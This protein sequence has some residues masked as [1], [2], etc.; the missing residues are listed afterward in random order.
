MLSTPT[1]ILVER[2][3]ELSPADI[4]ARELEADYVSHIMIENT[5]LGVYDAAYGMDDFLEVGEPAPSD[6]A[7]Q[8]LRRHLY[9]HPEL[10]EI[11]RWASY[12]PPPRPLEG[13]DVR[14][15]RPQRPERPA[16]SRHGRAN[17]VGGSG[18]GEQEVP[19]G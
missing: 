3:R 14:L 6:L 10:R 18:T 5:P 8:A 2:I 4:Q 9:E 1:P 11:P 19:H 13:K 16:P 15:P 7:E 17:R 12:Y